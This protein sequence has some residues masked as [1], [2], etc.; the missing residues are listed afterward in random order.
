ME[1]KIINSDVK[2]IDDFAAVFKKFKAEIAKVIVGQ[3]DV[4]EQVLI[5]IF[6]SQNLLNIIGP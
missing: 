4:V 3:D 5:S 1:E 6:S 2:S